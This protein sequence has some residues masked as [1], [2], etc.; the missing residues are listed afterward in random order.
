MAPAA[1]SPACRPEDHKVM[2]LAD[3][4]KSIDDALDALAGLTHAYPVFRRPCHGLVRDKTFGE[5]QQQVCTGNQPSAYA[6]ILNLVTG[7]FRRAGFAN[8]AHARRWHARDDQRILAL[9]GYT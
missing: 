1:S 2:V 5:D 4:N 7:A 6:A 9:Y 8:I 3:E